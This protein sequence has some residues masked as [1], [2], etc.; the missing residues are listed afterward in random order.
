MGR[1]DSAVTLAREAKDCAGRISQ[2]QVV[3]EASFVLGMIATSSPSSVSEKAL[4]FFREG[5]DSIAQEPVTEI[6]WKLAL[7]LGQEFRKRGQRDKAKE[8]FTKA[9]LVLRFFLAQFTSSELKNGYLMM[10]NKQK[11]I[12]SLDSYL[13]M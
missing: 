10:G 6:T 12:A 11:I 7:A 8:C 13:N 4:P 5:F 1:H 2:P 3:A 9:R